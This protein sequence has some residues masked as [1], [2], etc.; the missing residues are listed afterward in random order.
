VFIKEDVSYICL[1]GCGLRMLLDAH[2]FPFHK[3][4]FCVAVFL[5]MLNFSICS[6]I[7][8]LIEVSSRVILSLCLSKLS[9]HSKIL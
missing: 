6:L 3:L 2:C 7:C 9:Y 5:V 1:C 4:F 8:A